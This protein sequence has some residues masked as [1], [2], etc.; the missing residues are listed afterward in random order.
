MILYG[1]DGNPIRIDTRTEQQK[2]FDR[3]LRMQMGDNGG[4]YFP[5]RV[6]EQLKSEMLRRPVKEDKAPGESFGSLF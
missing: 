3:E 2:E 5:R 4:Q 6:I 1:P